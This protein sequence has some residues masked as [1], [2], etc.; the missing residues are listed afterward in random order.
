M[1]WSR[2][3]SMLVLGITSLGAQTHQGVH[4][5]AKILGALIYTDLSVSFDGEEANEIMRQLED[6]LGVLMQV[7]WTTKNLDGC[8]RAAPIFLKLERQPALIVLE[9]VIEQLS[10]DEETTWQMRDGVLEVG[11]KSR[12][13]KSSS[14]QTTTYS[15]GDLLFVVR[16]FDNAPEMGTGGGGTGGGGGGNS[17]GVGFGTPGAD[18]ESLTKQERIDRIIELITTFVEPPQWE[19]NGGECTITSFNEMLII[20]APNY[21]HRQIGGYP[22]V[23]VRPESARKRHVKYSNGRTTVR[24]PGR[25]SQ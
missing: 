17:G 7:Y 20:R 19:K 24:V 10:E 1:R 23:A 2:I 22:F 18:P 16:D 21:V 9:R 14:H 12:F 8:E 5:H 11:L 25:P 6:D 13:S 3:T 4:P 15:I